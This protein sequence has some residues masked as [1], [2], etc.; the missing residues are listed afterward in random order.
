MDGLGQSQLEDLGL[1]STLEEVL[2]LEP[3]HVIE[4]VLGL[5]EH[6]QAM[7]AAHDG[8][9]FEQSSGVLLV[10]GQKVTRSFTNFGDGQL[11]PPDLALV[12]QTEF[13][14]QLQLCVETLL[15]ERSSKNFIYSPTF[16]NT[17]HKHGIW[18]LITDKPISY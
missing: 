10:E 17:L 3:E 16:K 13:A 2:D 7:E 1:E 4:L 15:I 12:L 18:N 8:V 5:L 11:H 9:S 6:A 14:D